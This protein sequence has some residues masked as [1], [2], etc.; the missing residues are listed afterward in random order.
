MQIVLRHLKFNNTNA[1]VRGFGG[2]GFYKGTIASIDKKEIIHF[3]WY[4]FVKKLSDDLI[5]S[6]FFQIHNLYLLFSD[7]KNWK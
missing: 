6:Y 7:R 4:S 5:L 1:F 2:V 3:F